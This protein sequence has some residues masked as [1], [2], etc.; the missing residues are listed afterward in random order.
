VKP[1][2]W[3]SGNIR[4]A[5]VFVVHA[6]FFFCGSIILH[7]FWKIH[8]DDIVTTTTTTIIIIIITP[9]SE[10]LSIF[11]SWVQH[12]FIVILVSILSFDR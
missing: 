10:G 1:C 8:D 12:A 5:V 6:F 4:S 11:L 3:Q 2:P 9:F 7:V